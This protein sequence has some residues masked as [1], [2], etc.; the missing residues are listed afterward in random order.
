MRK[1]VAREYDEI[2]TGKVSL[3]HC[4]CDRSVKNVSL[5][6]TGLLISA[7]NGKVIHSVLFPVTCQ[8][9]SLSYVPMC[10]LSSAESLLCTKH[11]AWRRCGLSSHR[12]GFHGWSH[13]KIP[14]L[15]NESFK[16]SLHFLSLS[17][18]WQVY[19]RIKDDEWNVYRRYTAFRSLHHKLQN[20]YPQ[21]RSYN[22]PPKK[23]IGN[24]VPSPREARQLTH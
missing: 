13:A 3:L 14:S 16:R 18:S 2:L 7:D 12:A 22:F 1:C 24:K 21:V 23:A 10:S 8:V 17:L 9:E 4:A 6:L 19:I 15:C 5:R 11:W 20:K